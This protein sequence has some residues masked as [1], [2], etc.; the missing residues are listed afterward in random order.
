MRYKEFGEVNEQSIL[1]NC[2]K[3]IGDIKKEFGL[4]LEEEKIMKINDSSDFTSIESRGISRV[5]TKDSRNSSYKENVDS[6]VND[7][8]S[9]NVYNGGYSIDGD[10]RKTS[11]A[12]YVLVVAALI[13][14][15]ILVYVVTTTI[16]GMVDI[17]IIG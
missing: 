14:L 13:A 5:L 16:L 17:E 1:D 8:N 6:S 9:N 15:V 3:V 12:S 10:V 7:F 4:I 2:P 11:G